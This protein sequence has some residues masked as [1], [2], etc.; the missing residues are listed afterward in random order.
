MYRENI[1]LFHYAC[2]TGIIECTQVFVRTDNCIFTGIKINYLCM[3]Q[4][5]QL[6][7]AIVLAYGGGRLPIDCRA[8]AYTAVAHSEAGIVPGAVYDTI[9]IGT[10]VLFLISVLQANNNHVVGA[11]LT[12]K[13]GFLVSRLS[14]HSAIPPGYAHR[15]A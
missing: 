7:F 12:T 15:S 14:R 10:L 11:Y 3:F 5:T 2:E 1:Y 6:D 8:I 13:R 4:A 9:L